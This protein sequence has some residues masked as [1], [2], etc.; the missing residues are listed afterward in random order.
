MFKQGKRLPNPF[1][2]IN[3][4]NG[5]SYKGEWFPSR[6]KLI[7]SYTIE[8]PKIV[9]LNRRMRIQ[10]S[11]DAQ[12]DYLVRS[13]EPGDFQLTLNGV[14]CPYVMN[15]WNGSG[16]LNIEMPE[17][18]EVGDVLHFR[19][20]VTDISRHTPF[21]DDFYVV[22][23]QEE[24]KVQGRPGK[25]TNQGN[26]QGNN[27]SNNDHMSLPEVFEVRRKEWERF[28][29]DGESAL[30]ARYNGETWILWSTWIIFLL[31]TNLKQQIRI[32]SGCL[33]R[34]LNMD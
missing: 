12:N 26:N 23:G 13:K 7:K 15:L 17:E 30:K 1:K 22:I 6:F 9:S 8:S 33:R 29:F 20:T 4:K 10:Y 32:M 14:S 16:N 31:N 28:N 25:R 2:T 5:S 3:T 19:S 21:E 18:V 24:K 27:S 34:G 11:T